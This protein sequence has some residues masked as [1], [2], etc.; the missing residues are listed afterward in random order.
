LAGNPGGSGNPGALGGTGSSFVTLSPGT[1]N[2]PVN[3]GAGGFVNI[4]WNPQ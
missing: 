4:S 3:V 2:V 1:T